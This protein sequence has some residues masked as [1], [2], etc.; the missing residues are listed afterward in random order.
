MKSR[1]A[2]FVSLDKFFQTDKFT[3][4][5]DFITGNE[6]YG[7]QSF[8][9]VSAGTVEVR[10]NLEKFLINEGFGINPQYAPGHSTAEVRVSYFRGD[11]WNS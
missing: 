10:R 7:K 11:G 4:K 6:T 8:I 1:K 2:L 3:K 5:G 9:Y